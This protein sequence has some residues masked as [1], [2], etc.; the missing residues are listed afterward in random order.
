[1]G[2]VQNEISQLDSKWDT[3]MVAR[4]QSFQEEF[5]GRMLSLFEK[6]LGSASAQA[7]GKGILGGP[8]PGLPTKEGL[9]MAPPSTG[10]SN[11]NSPRTNL[12][13]E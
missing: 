9:D 13:L 10:H 8:P 11:A 2:K 12:F 5:E 3:K 1:M 6:Y 4:F 7:K